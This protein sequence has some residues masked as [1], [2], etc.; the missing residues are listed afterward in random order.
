MTEKKTITDDKEFPWRLNDE[1]Q[2]AK[3]FLQVMNDVSYY[4][5]LQKS[6]RNVIWGNIMTRLLTTY[7]KSLRAPNNTQSPEH[8]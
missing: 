6:R 5:S 8:V 4:D 2:S 7:I 1:N 3:T